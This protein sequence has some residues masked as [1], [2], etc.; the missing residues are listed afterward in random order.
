MAPLHSS[1]KIAALYEYNS[2]QACRTYVNEA[3]VRALALVRSC[4]STSMKPRSP[5]AT[6]AFSASSFLPLGVRPTADSTR[7]VGYCP[8]PDHETLDTG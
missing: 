4:V 1:K 5:T 8:P 2:Q 3:Y 7:S 6:P